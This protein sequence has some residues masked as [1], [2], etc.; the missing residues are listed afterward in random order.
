MKLQ[1]QYV[2]VESHYLTVNKL[3]SMPVYLH[4]YYENNTTTYN[5]TTIQLK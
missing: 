3:Q 5:L 2:A 4:F 1:K